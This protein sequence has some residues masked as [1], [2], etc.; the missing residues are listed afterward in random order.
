MKVIKDYAVR[1][2]VK[3]LSDLPQ[4]LKLLDSP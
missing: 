2:K 1:F 3:V 4:L